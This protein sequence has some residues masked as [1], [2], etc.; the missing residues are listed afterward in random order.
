MKMF[1]PLRNQAVYQECSIH[2]EAAMSPESN[3]IAM[4]LQCFQKETRLP[5]GCK[6][7]ITK[8]PTMNKQF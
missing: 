2:S 8:N 3:E 7:I 1:N 5:C 4:W 6:T